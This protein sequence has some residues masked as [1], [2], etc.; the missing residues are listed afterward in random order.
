VRGREKKEE[1]PT[2][3]IL[4]LHGFRKIASRFW[5]LYFLTEQALE[6]NQVPFQETS[7]R[8]KLNEILRNQLGHFSMDFFFLQIEID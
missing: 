5:R 4:K 1:K 3:N 7:K 2:F 8:K 6:I